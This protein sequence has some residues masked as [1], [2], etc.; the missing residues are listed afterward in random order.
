M[1]VVKVTDA[2]IWDGYWKAVGWPQNRH[3]ALRW[4]RE[5]GPVPEGAS[6]EL[7]RPLAPV[8]VQQ[9]IRE[10]GPPNDWL[11]P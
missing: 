11:S 3:A 9:L 7:F 6:F 10:M 5:P 1:I 4:W 2:E 8:A